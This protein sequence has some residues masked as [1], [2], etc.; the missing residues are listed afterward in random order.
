M[1]NFEKDFELCP[2]DGVRIIKT[3]GCRIDNHRTV[4]FDPNGD[5]DPKRQA[6]IA[7]HTERVQKELHERNDT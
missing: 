5:L 7:A 2:S 4:T 3:Q 6:R 1:K